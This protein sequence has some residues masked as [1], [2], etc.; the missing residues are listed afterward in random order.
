MVHPLPSHFLSVGVLQAHHHKCEDAKVVKAASSYIKDAKKRIDRGAKKKS[1]AAVLP[2]EAP[3]SMAL[4]FLDREAVQGGVGEDDDDD[5]DD[6][7]DRGDHE[8][9]IERNVDQDSEESDDGEIGK[10]NEHASSK[11]AFESD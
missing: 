4:N 8:F 10:I 5:D 9:V 7:D 3:P 11:Y 2:D 6:D 1:N